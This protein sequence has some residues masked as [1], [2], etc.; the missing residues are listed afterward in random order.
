MGLPKLSESL[1]YSPEVRTREKSGA[2][3]PMAVSPLNPEIGVFLYI[4]KDI[5][6]T[7]QTKNKNVKKATRYILRLVIGF[8]VGAITHILPLY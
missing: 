8:I 3:L 7:A 5:K 4:P 2:G 1:K 6:M